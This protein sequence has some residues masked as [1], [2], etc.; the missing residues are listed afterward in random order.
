MLKKMLPPHNR[1]IPELA[2]EEGISEAALYV[3]RKA[4]RAEGRL[5]SDGDQTPAGWATA[6]L[7]E[8]QLSAWCRERGLYPEQV[9]AWRR[10]CEQANDWGR[11]QAE[12]LKTERKADRE[13]LKALE[14]EFNKKEKALAET[15]ALLVLSK[16]RGDLGGRRGRMT[17]VLD[18]RRALEPIE[19]A[20]AQVGR[21]ENVCEILG[22]S[23]RTY[24]RWTRGGGIEPDG[25]PEPSR[26]TPANRLSEAE[27]AHIVAVCNRPEYT[28]LP[29]SQIVLALADR[30]EYLASESTFYRVLS[31]AGQ[32]NRR[33][34]AQLPQRRVK[35]TSYC[36][37]GPNQVRSW[38]ITYLASAICSVFYRLYLVLDI[39]SRKVVGW[40]VHE[41]ESA[42]HTA[43]LV[44]KT[45]LAEG[46]TRADLILHADNGSPIKGAILLA[47]LQKLGVVASFSR[48][49]VSNDNPYSESLFRTLKYSPA[50][51][52][53]PFENLDAARQWAHEFVSWNNGRHRHSAL[54]FVTPN[55]RHE[56][57]DKAI[58]ER[59]GGVYEAARK[60]HPERWSGAIRKWKPVGEVWLNP[61]RSEMCLMQRTEGMAA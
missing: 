55:E 47:T 39:C 23:T 36:A 57:R 46:V 26:P 53:E 4:A 50:W 30:G 61:E 28:S 17:S 52:Q 38:D 12:R 43:E 29:P 56:G 10:A 21:Q 22:I 9:R 60:R 34:R 42:A 45:C 51:P 1:S 40:E 8:A 48:P 20:I 32:A 13:R 25:R 44:R 59:R 58:L 7:N 27:R 49:A 14:R 5:L 18:R 11:Q 16:S 24:Q 54:K 35:P 37:T 3:W 41:R 19:E 15:A 6:T 33:G 31:E 2:E